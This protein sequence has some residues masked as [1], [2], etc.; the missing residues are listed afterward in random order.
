MAPFDTNLTL[1]RCKYF[2][3]QVLR[4]ELINVAL[5]INIASSSPVNFR[6]AERETNGDGDEICAIFESVFGLMSLLARHWSRL[7]C[8]CFRIFATWVSTLWYAHENL[9]SRTI[10]PLSTSSFPLWQFSHNQPAFYRFA[11][12]Q[13]SRHNFS[14]S[15]RTKNT[16]LFY[17]FLY[18][19]EYVLAFEFSSIKKN[20]SWSLRE[21]TQCSLL[22]RI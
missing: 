2:C 10:R 20:S 12:I 6:D 16:L 8:R 22:Y 1:R 7:N 14:H 17:S 3:D 5:L 11:D 9:I 19:W 4:W 21:M 15:V 13:S 18:L